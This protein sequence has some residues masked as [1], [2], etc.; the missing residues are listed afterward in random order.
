M[1]DRLIDRLAQE[2]GD[3]LHAVWLFGSRARRDALHEYSD[4]DL[5]VV[6]SRPQDV[7]WRALD[8]AREIEGEEDARLTLINPTVVDVEKVARDRAAQRWL[9]Q[10]VDRDKIVLW[11]GEVEAPASFTW[12]EPE[13]PVRQRTRDYLAQAH[14][15]LEDAERDWSHGSL[16]S[17]IN[18]AYYAGFNAAAAALS[19]EDRFAK[20]HDG[21]WGLASRLL[22]KTGKLG[23][24][25]H[26][27]AHALKPAREM[28]VYGP[29][30]LDA[31]WPKPTQAQAEAALQTARDYLLSVEELLGV[32]GGA[33]P[34]R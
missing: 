12:Y 25:L 23:A 2:F 22:V 27:R 7:H 24:D 28:A 3:D 10:E 32:A 13:G 20:T 1:V 16:K 21:T 29:P 18:H 30:D 9:M 31:P 15:D 6:T 17:V 8:L 14:Q 26:G 4:I 19:E 5:M 34:D 33:Q 11:G